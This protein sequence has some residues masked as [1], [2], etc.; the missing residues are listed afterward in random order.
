MTALNIG[1]T[2]LDDGTPYLIA[3]AGV[4]HNGD[5]ELAHRLVE[6]GAVSG[7]DAIKFQLFEPATLVRPETPSAE[8]QRKVSSNQ[9]DMLRRLELPRPAFKELAEHAREQGVHFLCTPFSIDAAEFL[10]EDL[11]VDAVKVSSGDLTFTPLLR[12]LAG[13]GLPVLL[14]TGM[15]SM[16]EIERALDDLEGAPVILLHCLSQY[17]APPEDLNLRA[18][19]SLQK[20]TDGPVGYSDHAKAITP[21]LLAAALGA[22]VFEKH[23]TLDTSMPG[24]D[25]AASMAPE[26]LNH[27]VAEIRNTFVL[28][29]DGVKRRMPSELETASLARRSIV[30]LV[31]LPPGTVVEAKFVTALRPADGISPQDID[32]VIGRRTVKAV[33]EGQPLKWEQLEVTDA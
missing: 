12:Y 16:T 22:T 23:F 33:Y 17:P 32:L 13:T 2:R 11:Q 27:W 19:A 24:P 18:I 7:A 10:V 4:N 30:A 8:Y 3:E 28:L 14:S 25:H 9:F 31:D 6:V 29:G 5:E 26:E 15:A 20:L 21:S 1:K